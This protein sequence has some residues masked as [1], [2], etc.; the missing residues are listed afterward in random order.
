MWQTACQRHE[1]WVQP[2]SEPRSPAI[3]V[4]WTEHEIPLGCQ[5]RGRALRP[6]RQLAL[7]AAVQQKQHRPVYVE[8]WTSSTLDNTFMDFCCVF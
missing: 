3:H 1:L 8:T 2:E 6:A 5:I 7:P 4:W